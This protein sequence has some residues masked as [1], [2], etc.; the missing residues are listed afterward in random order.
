MIKCVYKTTSAKLDLS[1]RGR[2]FTN[3][4]LQPRIIRLVSLLARKLTFVFPKLSEEHIELGCD[5]ALC[6]RTVVWHKNIDTWLLLDRENFSPIGQCLLWCLLCLHTHTRARAHAQI[7]PHNRVP[8]LH[9]RAHA[10]RTRPDR[11][12]L[13]A[14]YTVSGLTRCSGHNIKVEYRWMDG[15]HSH[16]TFT[17]ELVDKSWRV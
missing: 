15:K 13:L 7:H 2:R 5:C 17:A 4:S 3:Q 14:G 9:T 11:E 12:E 6:L 10:Y 1:F 16:G 8:A